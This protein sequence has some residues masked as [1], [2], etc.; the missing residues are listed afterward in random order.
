MAK[1]LYLDNFNNFDFF[2]EVSRS[3]S[4][5]DMD[6]IVFNSEKENIVKN[7]SFRSYKLKASFISTS[8]TELITEEEYRIAIKNDR[9][10]KLLPTGLSMSLMR[11]YI[12]QIEKIIE[13]NNYDLVLGE[14]SWALEY[15]VFLLCER[16]GIKY[17]HL[18][19]LPLNTVRAVTFD[20]E[21]SMASLAEC[22]NCHTEAEFKISYSDICLRV[23]ECF[24]KGN[25]PASYKALI[26]S[27][28]R[29]WKPLWWLSAFSYHVNK[30]TYAPLYKKSAVTL[31]EA[32]NEP[33]KKVL[34]FPL[35]VQPESTPDYVSP[36]YSEQF[37][38][39]AKVSE[40]LGDE[41]VILVKEHPNKF[42][43][44]SVKGFERLKRIKNVIFLSL[45][46]NAKDI[47]EKA[48]LV[49]TIAGTSCL[50]AANVRKPAIAFSNIY[51]TALPGV[52]DG[53]QALEQNKL[54]SF[55]ETAL[56]HTEFSDN[57]NGLVEG[58]GVTGFVHDPML[59]PE[60][61]ESQNLKAVEDL[62]V[63]LC[64]NRI[65]S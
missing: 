9:L 1:V 35:H 43:P 57:A 2:L 58:F 19:Y 56:G 18:L 22:A 21:H 17:R 8:M 61:F 60:L 33:D 44:R 29:E 48:D 12:D 62:I 16:K 34:Y 41:F 59:F 64:E 32:L 65:D 13:S 45:S 23:K 4:Y 14:I 38:L 28:Y 52:F 63:H 30:H 39:I 3:S 55:V 25:I 49:L 24:E 26:S 10:L 6:F 27:D 51:Y 46:E 53:R 50:E 15:L 37:E 54:K 40:Q 20:A 36:Y 5:I 31:Q 11:N 47:M 7:S 42:S